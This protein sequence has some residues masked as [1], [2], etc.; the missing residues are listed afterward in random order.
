MSLFINA[1]EGFDNESV[2]GSHS[3]RTP[4]VFTGGE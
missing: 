1:S 3:H 2:L 4:V